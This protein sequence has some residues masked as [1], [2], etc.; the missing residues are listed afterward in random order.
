MPRKYTYT[1]TKTFKPGKVSKAGEI[2]ADRVK[3]RKKLQ[4]HGLGET[5]FFVLLAADKMQQINKGLFTITDIMNE[6]EKKRAATEQQLMKL[7]N[8]GFIERV[9]LGG[10]YSRTQ[11][12]ITKEGF[13]LIKRGGRLFFSAPV[14][15]ASPAI[16]HSGP[17]QTTHNSKADALTGLTFTPLDL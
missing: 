2:A 15:P 7:V 13:A 4:K 17:L 8:G 11:Y 10:F 6:L 1:R 3:F 5:A 16:S 12:A 14:V 9:I